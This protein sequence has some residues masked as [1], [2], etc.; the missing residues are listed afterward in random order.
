MSACHILLTS[1]E[2]AVE[3]HFLATRAAAVQ[4]STVLSLDFISGDV[5]CCQSKVTGMD[6][7]NKLM[8][9]IIL[10]ETFPSNLHSV[11][12]RLSPSYF[13]NVLRL[14]LKF[15]SNLS[16]SVKGRCVYHNLELHEFPP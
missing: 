13:K 8:L 12:Y 9:H 16:F 10:W 4:E 5:Y 6:H 14:N 2:E 1:L 11:H 7:V 15:L 3:R